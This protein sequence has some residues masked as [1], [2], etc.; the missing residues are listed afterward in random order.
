MEGVVAA[1]TSRAIWTQLSAAQRLEL[2]VDLVSSR[3]NYIKGQRISEENRQQLLQCASPNELQAAMKIASAR[4]QKASP[5]LSMLTNALGNFAAA[6]VATAP[7]GEH[8]KPEIAAPTHSIFISYLRSDTADATGRIFDGLVSRFGRGAV[9][10]DVDTIPL[11]SDWRRF[12]AQT[13]SKAKVVLVVIGDRWL[14]YDDSYQRRIDAKDD[15]VRQE[16]ESAIDAQIP[17]IPVLIGNAMLQAKDELPYSIREL[18]QRNAVRLQSGA[19][20][21]V[22]LNRLLSGVSSYL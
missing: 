16:I 20:F 11:G 14:D 4:T 10:Y 2:L 5:L 7:E 8:K 1:V 22:Q 6:A 3:D 9:N 15:T 18:G 13:I 12:I 17:I 21:Q 19:D